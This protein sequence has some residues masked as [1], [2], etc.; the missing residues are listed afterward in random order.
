M[1]RPSASSATPR[2]P[3]DGADGELRALLAGL[4]AD[5]SSESPRLARVLAEL[6]DQADEAG[7]ADRAGASALAQ[8]AAYLRTKEA[9]DRARMAFEDRQRWH[10]RLS[11]RLVRSVM[12]FGV[13]AVAVF[14]LWGGEKG[15][16][17][18]IFFVAGGATF[19]FMAQA[20]LVWRL[21]GD[22]R[23]LADV[24]RRCRGELDELAGALG[25][26]TRRD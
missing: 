10:R 15:F 11:W 5:E 4:V 14:A 20:T 24:E 7:G 2:A 13:L 1:S 18:A 19:Y 23:A 16:E 22:E 8:L 26:R 12:L 25:V 17:A 6:G 3:R 9:Q 21:K